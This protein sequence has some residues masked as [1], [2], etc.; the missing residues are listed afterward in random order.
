MRRARRGDSA[1]FALVVRRYYRAVLYEAL[2]KLGDYHAAEDAAQ[3]TFLRAYRGLGS[4]QPRG[5]LRPWLLRIC[6]NVCADI[7]RNRRRRPY[8]SLNDVAEPVFE[9]PAR[10]D[11]IDIQ[12]ALAGLQ[13][14]EREAVM[15]VDVLG[16]RSWEAA[17][18]AGVP[19]STVRSRTAR[20]R[21]RLKQ[22]LTEP[23]NQPPSSTAARLRQAPRYTG[24]AQC[25]AR[26][27]PVSVV[28]PGSR[29]VV[30][31]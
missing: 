9:P 1:A 13:R 5:M 24:R 29:D 4:Y 14:E 20:G 17:I 19:P 28:N 3:D 30:G 2:W 8:V 12:R 21:T 7:D 25:A 11:R 31:M 22:A 23:R 18:M 6:H 16:Y 27:V 26:A 10:D 15:R